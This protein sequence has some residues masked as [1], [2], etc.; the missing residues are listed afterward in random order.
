MQ[1]YVLNVTINVLCR[2]VKAEMQVK[3]KEVSDNCWIFQR[4][5]KNI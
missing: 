2:K 3:K 1:E 4:D 5:D